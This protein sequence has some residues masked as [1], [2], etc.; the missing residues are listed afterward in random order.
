MI[1]VE[2]K[3]IPTIESIQDV[4]LDNPIEVLKVCQQLQM[5][6]EKERGIGISAVQAGIPWK[7]FLIKG[8]G[9]CPLLP[10]DQYG[11]FV[12]CTY[13]ATNEERVVSLEGCL[14]L[15]SPEGRLRSFQVERSNYI[16][17]NGYRLTIDSKISFLE[18]DTE[19][20]VHQQGIVFQHEIDHHRGTLISD[21]GKEIFVW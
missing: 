5:L 18:F 3:D 7:L 2:T 15:R 21:I 12:N 16:K 20:G 11:Y 10:K 13:T 4:P 17:I 8:D 19:I 1:I 9:T 6:C 14:S